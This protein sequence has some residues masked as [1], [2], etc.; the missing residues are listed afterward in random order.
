MGVA[1]S[2][3]VIVIVVAVPSVANAYDELRV[4]VIVGGVES[5]T[6]LKDAPFV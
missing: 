1:G 2:V 3:A 4:L 6:K 5:N